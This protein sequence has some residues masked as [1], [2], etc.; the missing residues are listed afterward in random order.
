MK[1]VKENIML[2]TMAAKND[3]IL[4]ML[5]KRKKRGKEQTNYHQFQDPKLASTPIESPIKIKIS[6]TKSITE[7]E[8]ETAV[9]EHRR[10]MSK[11]Y[12][13]KQV[14]KF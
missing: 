14:R 4:N 11:K 5:L 1:I 12:L 7:Q 6:Q 3:S 10:K 2:S 9:R 13:T 8:F